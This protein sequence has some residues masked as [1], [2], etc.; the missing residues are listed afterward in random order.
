MKERIS[1]RARSGQWQHPH[2][3]RAE[4]AEKVLDDR[5]QVV[6]IDRSH[7]VSQAAREAGPGK[8]ECELPALLHSGLH[9]A[10]R[11]DRGRRRESRAQLEEPEREGLGAEVM[12]PVVD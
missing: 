10:L 6:E 5:F 8:R 7:L 4:R 1:A 3:A 11:V 12:V 2:A 9:F